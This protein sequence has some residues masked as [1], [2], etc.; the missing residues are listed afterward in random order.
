MAASATHPVLRYSGPIRQAVPYA[1]PTG[2]P[3][4]QRQTIVTIAGFIKVMVC[5]HLYTSTTIHITRAGWHCT[6]GV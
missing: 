1:A 2:L 4:P 3:P 5:V 6:S